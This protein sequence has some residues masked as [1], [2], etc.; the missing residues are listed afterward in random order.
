MNLRLERHL[1]R[2]DL[3]THQKP[4]PRLIPSPET[5]D[6]ERQRLL[7]ESNG[8]DVL[9]PPDVPEHFVL[10]RWALVK[11]VDR[12]PQDLAREDRELVLDA[13][14]RLPRHLI[15]VRD[16]QVTVGEHDVAR[17]VL[18]HA[19]QALM[20]LPGRQRLECECGGRL[21][22]ASLCVHE[23]STLR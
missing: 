2:D 22:D 6:V 23:V 10:M 21:C 15:Q 1:S 14:E 4:E 16:A 8:R 19:A 9:G 20:L 12:L 17:D 18:E 7:P 5:L 11:D 13:L 3:P